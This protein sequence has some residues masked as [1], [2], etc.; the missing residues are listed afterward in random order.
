MH[1]Y[2]YI[3]ILATVL[4]PI[5]AHSQFTISGEF[6]PRAEYRNGYKTLFTNFDDNAFFI[7]QRIRLSLYFKID[8][9]T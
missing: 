2:S 8:I 9:Q 6:R 3:F 1:I 4:F 5:R 7:D